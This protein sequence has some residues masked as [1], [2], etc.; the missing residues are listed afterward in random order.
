VVPLWLGGPDRLANVR[1]VCERC[2]AAKTKREATLRAK[3]RRKARKHAE[4]RRRMKERGR[5]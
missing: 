1:V 2:H 4:H 5:G 3:V